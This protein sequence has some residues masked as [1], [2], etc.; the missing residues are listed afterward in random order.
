[1]YLVTGG[2]GFIG[3][4]LVRALNARGIDEVL[5]ADDLNAPAKVENLH[6]CRV[7]KRIGKAELRR[8]VER[9]ALPELTAILHHGACSDTLCDDEPFLRDNNVA[10]SVALLDLALRRRTPFVYAG[11]MA[12]Y[13]RAPAAEE[14]LNAYACSKL[15]FDR[16][17]R[18]VLPEAASTVVGLR[19]AN[20]YGPRERHKGRMASMV[21][22]IYR[23]IVETGVARLFEGTAA[24]AAGEQRR[25]FVYVDDVVRVVLELANGPVRHGIVDVGTGRGRSFN[26]LAELVIAAVGDGRVE[27]VPLEPELRGRYQSLMEADL[28]GLRALGVEPPATP[29][30]E[31][32]PK[33]VAAWRREKQA[34]LAPMH[35]F[36]AKLTQPSVVE[37]L[38]A[39][40]RWQRE[41]RRQRDEGVALETALADAPD[42][43]PLSINLD[44]TT[45]CNYRCDHCVDMHILNTGIHHDQETLLDSLTCLAEHG[46]RS[47]ILIGGGEPTVHPRFGEVVRH[48][49]AL[50]LKIGVVTNGSRLERVLEVADAFDGSDWVRLSLDS[51]ADATFQA[52]HLPRKAI[53]LEEICAGV[54]PLKDANPSLQV[55]FS[56]I[57]VW[58]GSEANGAKIHENVHEIVAA[59]ELAKAHRFD[60]IA[61]KPFLERVE[62]TNAEVINLTRDSRLVGDVMADIRRNLDEAA[63]LADDRFRVVESTNLR[64]LANGTY[65]E[66]T[67]QPATCHMTF[68]RQVVSP[69]GVFNCPVYRNVS[70]ARIGTK[71]AYAT[72]AAERQT[73]RDTLRTI[74]SFDA[75]ARCGEVTCL[76]NHANWF[77]EELI[78]HPHRLEELETSDERFDVFL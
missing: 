18:D 38:R 64:V 76:Y 72:D 20:V 35:D 22:R 47:V 51:G 52:M 1:M 29:L 23:Q 77:V 45:S 74:E 69:L 4:H 46:L 24:F 5:V 9:D 39:Y 58:G 30:E 61:F 3:S 41:W 48:L 10:A 27:Y 70:A 44:L 36:A 62:E 33:A 28:E 32:V 75:S 66:F 49:K 43:A 40:V 19:Y 15:D 8:L 50:G 13:G 11:S 71:T 2:A 17:V 6:G 12:V 55:G 42:L 56:F 7:A 73:V 78:E 16:H 14:P 63:Q 34:E 59:A 37:H 67:R 31:G 21:H 26:E 53:T 60:Y 54:P 65:R 68:F 57:I 25:D